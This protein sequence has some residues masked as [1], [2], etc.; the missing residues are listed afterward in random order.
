MNFTIFDINICFQN[1][2][3]YTIMLKLN[4]DS[5]KRDTINVFQKV[6]TTSSNKG[7]L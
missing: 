6:F 4:Q 7:F 5:S 1:R 2:K 3:V